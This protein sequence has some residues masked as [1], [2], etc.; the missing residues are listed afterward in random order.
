MQ[1]EKRMTHPTAVS[2]VENVRQFSPFT[3]DK[4]VGA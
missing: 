1:A 4:E 3:R 2:L